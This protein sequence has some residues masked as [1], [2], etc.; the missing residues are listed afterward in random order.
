[1]VGLVPLVVDCGGDVDHP[2]PHQEAGEDELEQDVAAEH[3]AVVI[4]FDV[5]EEPDRNSV[6]RYASKVR[7]TSLRIQR[8]RPHT[9][10]Y[11]AGETIAVLEFFALPRRVSSLL[12][13]T[14]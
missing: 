1:M 4:N 2:R 11:S 7:K 8:Q 12:P 5:F 10:R 9:V 3:D 6:R 14:T 13:V